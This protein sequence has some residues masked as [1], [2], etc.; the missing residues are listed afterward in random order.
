MYY[1]GVYVSVH[2]LYMH[3][4]HVYNHINT[5]IKM[6]KRMLGKMTYLYKTIDSKIPA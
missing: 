5:K 6:I 2:L 1:K 4:L 3:V